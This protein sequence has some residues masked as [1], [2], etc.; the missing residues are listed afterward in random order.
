MLP[1]TRPRLAHASPTPTLHATAMALHLLRPRAVAQTFFIDDDVKNFARLD[2]IVTLVDA[3]HIEQHLDEVKPEGVEN[4]AIEQVAL[5][6]RLLLN[7]IDL[8]PEEA[9]LRR[10]EAR[11][12][13]LNR[14]APIVRC[15][16]ASVALDHVFGIQA[17]ELERALERD[18]AFLQVDR[19]ETTALQCE[20]V[21]APWHSPGCDDLECADPMC[22]PAS[23]KVGHVHDSQVSSVGFLRGGELEMKR[24]NEWISTLLQVPS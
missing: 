13:L 3:K 12:K 1:T 8:V 16:N 23:R 20:P 18:S 11:L 2:G 4:E 10:V 5:A 22:G 17:F 6:D 15:E 9:D 19:D 14:Y 24:T 7:K 21:A